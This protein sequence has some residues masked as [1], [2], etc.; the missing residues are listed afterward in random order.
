MTD[1]KTEI[2]LS[3]H[4]G[5]ETKIKYIISMP[6]DPLT[7]QYIRDNYYPTSITYCQTCQAYTVAI[8]QSYREVTSNGGKTNG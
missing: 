3:C 6:L 4:G 7:H 5:C 1:F 2:K 8:L